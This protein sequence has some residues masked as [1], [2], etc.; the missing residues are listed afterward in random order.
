VLVDTKR[1]PVRA[2][3]KVGVVEFVSPDLEI[4]QVVDIVLLLDGVFELSRV[5]LP[6]LPVGE[7][8][9]DNDLVCIA[10]TD[11]RDIDDESEGDAVLD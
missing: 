2:F 7:I 10:D 11:A 9:R 3:V 6:K 1:E 8:E 5:V 4:V